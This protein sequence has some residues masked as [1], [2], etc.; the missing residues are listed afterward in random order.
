AT[1]SQYYDPPLPPQDAQTAT[2]YAGT[3]TTNNAQGST[4]LNPLNNFTSSTIPIQTN[5][6]PSSTLPGDNL[7]DTSQASLSSTTVGGIIGCIV[8]VFAITLYI[9]FQ[10]SRRR[11]QQRRRRDDDDDEDNHQQRLESLGKSNRPA[12]I[13]PFYYQQERNS[14]D[15]S[16]VELGATAEMLYNDV[17]VEG[18]KKSGNKVVYV[19]AGFSPSLPYPYPPPPPSFKKSKRRSRRRLK[20]V[21][22]KRLS[23]IEEVEYTPS[24]PLVKTLV[25]SES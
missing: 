1:T 17:L 19:A 12:F 9:Y 4:P 23:T 25:Y 22:V 13:P 18:D 24:S 16:I 7:P 3:S 20:M 21:P 2:V 8:A 14:L 10:K 5:T 15:V 11:N 6:Y